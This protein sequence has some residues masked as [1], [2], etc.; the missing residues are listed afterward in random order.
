MPSKSKWFFLLNLATLKRHT[1]NECV[2]RLF[3]SDLEFVLKLKHYETKKTMRNEKNLSVR[4][5]SIR[6]VGIVYYV[7]EFSNEQ[8]WLCK[9]RFGIIIV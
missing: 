8:K 3:P 1:Q 4:G 2:H 6:V 9:S 7:Y 5:E